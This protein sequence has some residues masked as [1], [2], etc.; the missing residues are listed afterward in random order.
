MRRDGAVAEATPSYARSRAR[1]RV[2]ITFPLVCLLVWLVAIEAVASIWPFAL[3]V[4]PQ[5]S[6]VAGFMWDEIK[7]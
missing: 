1:C 4:L 7:G 5:P 6:E 2:G 3:D